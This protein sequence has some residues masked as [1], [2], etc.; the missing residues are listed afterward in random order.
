MPQPGMRIQSVR[1]SETAWASIQESARLE[2]VSASQYVRE[3]AMAR[4]WYERARRGSP[5]AAELEEILRAAR[6][7][8]AGED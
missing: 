4:V 7:H 1:F 6:V 5:E 8:D 2:G 3:A